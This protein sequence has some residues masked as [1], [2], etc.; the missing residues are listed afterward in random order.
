[1]GGHTCN[2]DSPGSLLSQ[3]IRMEEKKRGGEEGKKWGGG[4]WIRD[5]EQREGKWKERS[6][7]EK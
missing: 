2:T 5:G 1:M 4:K 3:E 6:I 7:K